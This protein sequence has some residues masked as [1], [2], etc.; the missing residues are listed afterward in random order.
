MHCSS[1]RPQPAHPRSLGSKAWILPSSG[2]HRACGRKHTL[3]VLQKQPD[4]TIRR[5]A[6]SDRGQ[7]GQQQCPSARIAAVGNPRANR[8]SLGVAT[9]AFIRNLGRTPTGFLRGVGSGRSRLAAN[10]LALWRSRLAVP[11]TRARTQGRPP[12]PP[13]GFCAC[14][15]VDRLRLCPISHSA[16]L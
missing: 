15:L 13:D 16:E 9:G 10:W 4:Q 11:G 8:S 14:V 1:I 3:R 2:A 6:Y 7:S 12:R 5:R